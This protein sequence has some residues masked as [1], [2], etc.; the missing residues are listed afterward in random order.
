MENSY[1]TGVSHYCEG[2]EA[3]IR[4]SLTKPYPPEGRQQKQELQ[5]FHCQNENHNHRKLI[6][7]RMQ[8]IMSQ[9]KEQDKNPEKQLHEVEIGKL[10]EKNSEQ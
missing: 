7:M 3:H 2:T 4:F 5:S 10:P 8:R 6:K 9:M 1:T